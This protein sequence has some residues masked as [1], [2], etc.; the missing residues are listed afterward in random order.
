MLITR[1]TGRLYQKFSFR[2]NSVGCYLK[3]TLAGRGNVHIGCLAKQNGCWAEAGGVGLVCAASAEEPAFRCTCA[4]VSLVAS[5]S[6]SAHR[7]GRRPRG[8]PTRCVMSM[9]RAGADKGC[10]RDTVSPQ[11]CAHPSALPCGT[12]PAPVSTTGGCRVPGLHGPGGATRCSRGDPP[13]PGAA[14]APSPAQRVAAEA[15]GAPVRCSVPGGGQ[16][17]GDEPARTLHSPGR[18]RREASVVGE[19]PAPWLLPFSPRP[20]RTRR[21]WGAPYSLF[22]GRV[23]FFCPFQ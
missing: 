7:G 15:C 17:P 22:L 3:C 12:E 21:T 23:Y 8:G 20:G 14:A 1:G 16:R 6:R 9:V 4:G 13:P 10:A 2:C 19:P 18:P 11:L 5:E